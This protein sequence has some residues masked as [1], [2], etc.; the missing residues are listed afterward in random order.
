MMKSIHSRSSKLLQGSFFKILLDYLGDE[1]IPNAEL[2]RDE[3][4]FKDGGSFL[5]HNRAVLG[6][7]WVVDPRLFPGSTA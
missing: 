3:S 1:V 6:A 2:W 5:F 7:G 4:F